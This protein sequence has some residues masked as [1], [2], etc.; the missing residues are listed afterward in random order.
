MFLHEPYLLVIRLLIGGDSALMV[1][2]WREFAWTPTKIDF[3]SKVR[4]WNGIFGLGHHTTSNT[5]Q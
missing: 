2:E 1:T 4:V 3:F 5:E